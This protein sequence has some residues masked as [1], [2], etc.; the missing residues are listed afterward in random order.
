MAGNELPAAANV[1]QNS[2]RSRTVLVEVGMA[3]L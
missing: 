3:L 1:M 2:E